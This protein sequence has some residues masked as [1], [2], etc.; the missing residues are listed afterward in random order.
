MN[1]TIIAAFKRSERI[2]RSNGF[3][4]QQGPVDTAVQNAYE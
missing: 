1:I 2:F 4:I 3:E